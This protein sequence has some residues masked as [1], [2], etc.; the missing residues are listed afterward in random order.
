MILNERQRVNIVI[1]SSK[2]KYMMKYN[3][4]KFLASVAFG[5]GDDGAM[6]TGWLSWNDKVN[7]HRKDK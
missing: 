4:G 2:S 3:R 7:Y 6:L 5:W 1:V